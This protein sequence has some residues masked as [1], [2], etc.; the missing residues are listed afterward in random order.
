MGTIVIG[1]PMRKSMFFCLKSDEKLDDSS[2]T[3]SQRHVGLQLSL[4][5]YIVELEQQCFKDSINYN[6]KDL[7]FFTLH[8]CYI[9]LVKFGE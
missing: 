9:F 2:V 4:Y 6:S 8:G 1:N 3:D 5:G 7:K